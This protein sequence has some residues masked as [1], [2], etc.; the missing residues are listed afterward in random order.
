MM[1]V[2]TGLAIVAAAGAW[3]AP[4]TIDPDRVESRTVNLTQTVTLHDIPKG[5]KLVKMWVPVPSDTTWQRVLDLKVDSA[6]GNWKFIPHEEGRG[7]F[8]YAEIPNPTAETASVVVSCAVVRK[9]VHFPLEKASSSSEIQAELFSDSLD[10]KAPLMEVDQKVQE[11]A[12]KACGSE[13]DPA[14]QAIL[15]QQAVANSADHYSKDATKPV[16]GRGAASDCME[17]GGGCCTD[18][19]SL[20]IAAARSRGI[21][22]RMQYG[23]RMLDA[24]AGAPFDPGYRCWVEYFVP[25]AGWVPT[26]IVASDNADAA[27]PVR[28]ASLSATRVWLWEGRSFELTPKAKAGPI[29]TMTCGWAEIDGKPINPV[30]SR[31]GKTPAQLRRTVQFEI[32][33]TDRPAD[34]P[35]L[36]E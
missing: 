9:G 7:D 15:L 14:K 3:A 31:D 24:K 13:R 11:F 27:N 5:T 32:I 4:L 21:P 30:P 17:Q 23:Y 16:C 10:Q 29:H 26:D 19:H 22:A 2:L 28:W 35:K 34:A 1:R 6:P 25:G 8:V 36:P 18:L 20:F 12:D 33:K